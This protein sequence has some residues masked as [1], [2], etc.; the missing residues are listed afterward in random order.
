MFYAQK[1]NKVNVYEYNLNHIW[2]YLEIDWIAWD[3]KQT[4]NGETNFELNTN[5]YNLFI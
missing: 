4:E 2:I 1:K 3:V 5:I